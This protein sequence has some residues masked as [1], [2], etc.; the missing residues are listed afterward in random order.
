VPGELEAEVQPRRIGVGFQTPDPD[1]GHGRARGHL[2]VLPD[3][4]QQ[5]VHGLWFGQ[6]RQGRAVTVH[7]PQP[8]GDGHPRRAG[9]V[10]G[11]E[12]GI[13]AS[14]VPHRLGHR[15]TDLQ[16]GSFGQP[17]NFTLAHHA[18]GNCVGTALMLF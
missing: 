2:P 1:L 13:V 12:P 5:P 6:G 8:R 16:A 11:I 7:G 3:R 10:R 18:H 4:M 9:D 15:R 17:S 14:G